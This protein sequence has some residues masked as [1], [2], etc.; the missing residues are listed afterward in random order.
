MTGSSPHGQGHETVWA[1]VAADQLG[2]SMANVRVLC[3]DTAV[4]PYGIGTVGTNGAPLAASAV[5]VA[6][7]RVRAKVLDI[8]SRLLEVQPDDLTIVDGVVQVVGVPERSIPLQRIARMAY[9][10]AGMPTGVE[11][12]LDA[13]ARFRQSSEPFA[14]GAMIAVTFVDQRSGEVHVERIA[15]VDDCGR[16][17]NP[18]LLEG[19]TIGGVA[20]GLGQ[21]LSEQV[22][23]DDYG[24]PLHRSFLDYA[25]PR[26]EWMPELALDRTETPSPLNP[27]GAKGGAEG[28]N[29]AI[30]AAVYNSVLDAL[31]LLGV[32]EIAMPLTPQNVWRA[33]QSRVASRES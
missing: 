24:Q 30:P 21:I 9:G 10:G 22:V 32:T 6:G 33:I 29:I 1:Q 7:Q 16:A 17:L 23:Y 8:A 18:L 31:S 2:V 3:G 26:A 25:L 28:S 14:F 20:F 11:L 4:T 15:F 19:Q 27:L 13:S 5:A 12:G